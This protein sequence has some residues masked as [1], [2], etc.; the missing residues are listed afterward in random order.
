MK[1]HNSGW[2]SHLQRKSQTSW[3]WSSK[4]EK[5]VEPLEEAAKEKVNDGT[6]FGCF[7][8]IC[9][10]HYQEIDLPLFA[11]LG[12]YILGVVLQDS[13]SF[14]WIYEPF[15][16]GKAC[17]F[18]RTTEIIAQ[19]GIC[20]KMET[21]RCDSRDIGVSLCKML[22]YIIWYVMLWL[23]EYLLYLYELWYTVNMPNILVLNIFVD[24]GELFY[25]VG[26][27]IHWTHSLF[28]LWRMITHIRFCHFSVI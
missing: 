13:R 27:V 4:Q 6:S 26:L 21:F 5:W 12:L 15:V 2:L 24:L 8:A 11:G 28:F 3:L 23:F 25:Q 1:N 18:L 17:S 20:P 14:E 16:F 19:L 7:R 9:V 22:F 10:V